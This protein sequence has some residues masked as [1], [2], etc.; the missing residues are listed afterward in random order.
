[1]EDNFFSFNILSS[2]KIELLMYL[3]FSYNLLEK[4][5]KSEMHFFLLLLIQL[6]YMLDK[7]WHMDKGTCITTKNV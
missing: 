1:M 3:L 4:M 2:I 6:S 7:I 5:V